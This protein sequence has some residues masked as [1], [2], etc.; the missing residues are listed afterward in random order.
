MDLERGPP[1]DRPGRNSANV[2]STLSGLT[3]GS[4]KL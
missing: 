4:V 3:G 1:E 2:L